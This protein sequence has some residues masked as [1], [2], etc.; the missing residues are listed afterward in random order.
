MSF[1]LSRDELLTDYLRDQI[2][3]KKIA[4]PFP[5]SRDWAK[6]LGIGCRT[7]YRSLHSLE[8]EG[9]IEILPR[10]GVVL[11]CEN[12]PVIERPLIKTVRLVYQS[13]DHTDLYIRNRWCDF[14]FFLSQRLKLHDIHFVLEKCTDR[15]LRTI[16]RVPKNECFQELLILRSLRE[17]HQR[18]F[19]ECE[20]PCLVFGYRLP[21]INLPYV[22]F[23]LEGAI[24]HATHRFFRRG[25][26]HV[27]LLVNRCKSYGVHRQREA[28]SDA[29]RSWS[30]QRS[31]SG[32][33]VSV[34]IEP[35]LQLQALARFSSRPK[36]KH[37]ILVLAPLIFSTVVLSLLR[38][39]GNIFNEVEIVSLGGMADPASVWP[40]TVH[41]NIEIDAAIKAITHAA[42]HF[43]KRGTLSK[44]C[45]TI[46]VEISRP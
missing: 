33:I 41:Y 31:V 4:P 42:V 46:P 30:S 39:R 37:G 21:E 44:T 22:N 26:S 32:E 7:L 12:D 3:T 18:L 38:D 40:E 16:S 28:F 15:R 17:E 5:N 2:S 11:K 24:R 14:L 43:F 20:R 34:P 45:K 23:D 10:K 6:K 25:C 27:W 36:N 19:S 29:C 35:E 9:L 1:I 8:A 13:G